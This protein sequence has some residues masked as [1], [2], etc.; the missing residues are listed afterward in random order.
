MVSLSNHDRLKVRAG[1][2][3]VIPEGGL[4][5]KTLGKRA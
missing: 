3:H 4:Q 2:G 5:A 1:E